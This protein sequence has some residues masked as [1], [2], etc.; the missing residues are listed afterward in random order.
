MYLHTDDFRK[1]GYVRHFSFHPASEKIIIHVHASGPKS[2][3]RLDKVSKECCETA[4]QFFMAYG[5]LWLSF[6]C[7]TA[8]SLKFFV[9]TI[10][11]DKLL[12]NENF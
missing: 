3:R 10:G 11:N 7:L 8:E 2:S 5:E 1:I 12:I 4:P 6:L 9:I